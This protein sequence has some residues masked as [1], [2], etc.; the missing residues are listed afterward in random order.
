M[1]VKC[2]VQEFLAVVL[3]YVIAIRVEN[4]LLFATLFNQI[5]Y[6]DIVVD[7]KLLV[8]MFLEC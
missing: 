3:Q 1:E 6:V 2:H 7:A 8:E 4:H 5:D